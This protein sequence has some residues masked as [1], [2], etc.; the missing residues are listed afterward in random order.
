MT[1]PSQAAVGSPA[2]SSNGSTSV[3]GWP[4]VLAVGRAERRGQ[5]LEQRPV[6]VEGGR[7]P[8]GA[9]DRLDAT[10]AGR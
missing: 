3:D 9:G 8:A 5:P 10:A 6:G 1:L 4:E 2:G 7:H